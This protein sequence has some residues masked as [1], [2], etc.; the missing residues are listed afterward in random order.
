MASQVGGKQRPK[1]L[2]PPPLPA[3]STS[4]TEGTA[5]PPTD[6][7]PPQQPQTKRQ[8]PPVFNMYQES[9]FSKRHYTI[10]EHQ[11]TPLYAVTV[12]PGW[13][14]KPS[15]VLHG[16]PSDAHPPLAA[17]DQSSFGSAATVTLPPADAPPS[18]VAA[19]K[20]ESAGGGFRLPTYTFN[21]GTGLFQWR[22][23]GGAEV[24]SLDGRG[25]GWKLVRLA[26]DAPAA[27]GATFASDGGEVVAAWAWASGSLTKKFK[28]RFLGTGASGVLGERWAVMAVASALKI[29]DSERR[30]RN[31]AAG[32][33]GGA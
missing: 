17:I 3:Y 16:G 33:G 7:T 6:Q 2:P 8:F 9:G 1:S 15:V 22:H 14:G 5:P 21:V 31:A 28:F 25:A 26:P 30:R 24:R 23:S 19:V 4:T 11:A 29:W 32:G 13:S 10:G 27:R 20:I 12:Y 18:S